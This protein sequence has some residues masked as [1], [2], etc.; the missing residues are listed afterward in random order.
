MSYFK[1][2][3]TLSFLVFIVPI[4]SAQELPLIKIFTLEDYGNENQK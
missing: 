1:N 4:L 3:I 2:I